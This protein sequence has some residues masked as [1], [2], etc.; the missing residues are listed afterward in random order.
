MIPQGP[1][2]IKPYWINRGLVLVSLGNGY[3]WTVTQRW[4]GIAGLSGGP[5]KRGNP[6]GLVTGFSTTYGTG[7]TDRVDGPVFSPSI[8]H[9]SLVFWLYALGTGGNTNGRVFN[10]AGQDGI[11]A[12]NESLYVNAV[13]GSELTYNRRNSSTTGQWRLDG[14]GTGVELNKTNSYGLSMD[15]SVIGTTA[16]FMY[17]NGIAGSVTTVSATSGTLLSTPAAINIGNR[18]TDNLRVFDGFL[19]PLYMFDHPSAA[20][21]AEE[22]AILG[23]NPNALFDMGDDE[24]FIGFTAA[25]GAGRIFALAGF[26]GGLVGPSRGLA[27]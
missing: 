22:H 1:T 2:P 5:K 9:R 15:Q 7:T 17:K 26:G 19:G 25:P 20:L 8:Q 13:V 4:Q 27:A 23:R 24:D 18:S 12:G 3:F 11:S 10:G 6:L 21:T 14:S 16:P